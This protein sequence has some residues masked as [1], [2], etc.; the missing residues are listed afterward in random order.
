M[1]L[2]LQQRVQVSQ[3]L[4]IAP[5]LFQWLRLLQAPTQEL[6]Q[7][8]KQ[9]LESNPA[10]EID[11]GQEENE[12][13]PAQEE[14]NDYEDFSDPQ[15]LGK[16][17]GDDRISEKYDYLAEH[18]ADF[19]DDYPAGRH[20]TDNKAQS[21]SEFRYNSITSRETLQEHLRRQL[22]YTGL[23]EENLEIAEFIIGSLDRNGYLVTGLDELAAAA[24]KNVDE[25]RAV[26][27]VIQDLHP[28]GVGARDLREC[29][30]LQTKTHVENSVTR[31]IITNY[32]DALAR[33][34]HEGIALLLKV[35]VREVMEALKIIKTLDPKPGEKF[36]GNI[37]QYVTA[38]ITVHKQDGKDVIEI[39]DEYIP[40]VR[41]SASCE[42]LLNKPD[43][44]PDELAYLRKKIR[45]ANF[46]IQ[47]IQQ[48]HQTIR[49]VCRQIV[50][51]QREFLDT[52]DGKLKPLTMAQVA[53]L[54]GVHE[55]TVSRA[56][57]NKYIKTP[58][59]VFAMKH[60]FS[61]GYQC[62]DG[63][64]LTPEA[65]KELVSNEIEARNASTQLTDIQ[66]SG[67]FAQKGIKIARRT[68][69]KYRKELGIPSS[70]ER[71]PAYCRQVGACA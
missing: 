2:N 67:L 12:D 37:A 18:G 68:I 30:L 44:T 63:S 40:R 31:R 47:G 29:L 33:N 60:F 56:I 49:K 10:L 35:P 50:S 64:A 22:P 20:I 15:D 41:I 19:S 70:K 69:A 11:D 32:L 66:L 51:A 52:E 26:L 17:L 21:A 38:D 55:T 34:Q 3:Q 45:A 71:T 59:G 6:S 4:N 7:L 23:S 65:V 57:A 43:I 9:E 36:N 39:N 1:N 48:R 58:R 53:G 24:N 62:R 13:T 54:I 46:I 61:S 14:K 42:K 8:V 27:T 16:E 5:Q 25:I 28:H